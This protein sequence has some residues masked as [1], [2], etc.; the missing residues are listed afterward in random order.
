VKDSRKET[1]GIN[2]HFKRILPDF[3]YS[4]FQDL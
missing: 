2:E 4:K 3:R 1:G